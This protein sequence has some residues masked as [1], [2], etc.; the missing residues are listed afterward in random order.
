MVTRCEFNDW[1]EYMY[2]CVLGKEGPEK[3]RGKYLI[4][5]YSLSLLLDGGATPLAVRNHW[6]EQNWKKACKTAV[7]VWDLSSML[8]KQRWTGTVEYIWLEFRWESGAG[9]GYL[10]KLCG[11]GYLG[12]LQGKAIVKEIEKGVQS[13]WRT[14]IP[15]VCFFIMLSRHWTMH[16]TTQTFVLRSS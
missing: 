7:L 15:P 8:S 14:E 10:G 11:D 4:G 6:K 2:V 1:T 9:D 16:V 13:S 12:K 5:R 3:E